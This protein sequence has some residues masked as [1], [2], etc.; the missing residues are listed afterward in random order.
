MA[1]KTTSFVCGEC[2]YESGKWMG[3]CPG[4]GSW[5]TM[6]EE[7]QLPARQGSASV[8]DVL[9]EKPQRIGEIRPDNATRSSTG[10]TELDRVLG[11]GLVRGS[12]V[13]LGGDPGIGK[14]TLLLQVCDELSKSMRVLYASGEESAAQ[15]RLRAQRLGVTGKALFVVAEN[16]LDVILAQAEATKCAVLVVDSV[17][18][19]YRQEV[20]SA[21]GSVTQVREAT[22]ALTRLAKQNG[23]SVII[24]GHVTKEG[25]I[26]GPRVLEHLVDTV[27][28]FEGDRYESFRILRAVKNRFGSTNEIGVFEM[29]ERGMKEVPDPSA[30]FLSDRGTPLPGC[31][32]VC[33]MEGSRPVL[34]ELQALVCQTAFGTPRRMTAGLDHNRMALLIA[35]LE[36]KLGLRMGDQDA[37]I[38]IVGGLKV[39]ERAADLAVAVA[40]AASL[41]NAPVRKGTVVLGEIGLTGEVRAVSNAEKRVAE[42]AKMGF[43]RV[44]LP[45][46]SRKGLSAAG[47][48]LIGVDTVAEAFEAAF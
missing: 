14:S 25:A 7:I 39:D 12:A 9:L 11:G 33:V 5:N 8:P 34:V 16:D 26:A 4:C 24:V 20:T 18:T 13:L 10:L 21:P 23:I 35:V 1:K 3:K 36:K 44:I 40:L 42:C 38:N 31:A 43:E 41:R 6:V 32:V 46:S 48:E 28:Y 30:L 27:L 29:Q 22:T 2:G 45:R 37:Y 17:Q 15:I 19:V 47:M